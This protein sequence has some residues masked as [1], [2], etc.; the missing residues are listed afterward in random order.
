MTPF[1]DCICKNCENWVRYS[2]KIERNLAGNE[3][4]MCKLRN[5][6]C[7]ERRYCEEPSQ[8]YPTVEYKLSK[9]N[10]EFE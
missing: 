8:F 10:G 9:T 7:N 2:N 1:N 5:E 6:K 4:R 3:L